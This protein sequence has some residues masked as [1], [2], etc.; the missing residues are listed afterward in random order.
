M[1]TFN[2]QVSTQWDGLR[3]FGYLDDGRFYNGVTMADIHGVGER[4]EKSTVNGIQGERDTWRNRSLP[5][6]FRNGSS[7]GNP[8]SPETDSRRDG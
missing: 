7:A 1:W 3:H 8:C 2:S 5:S 4:G 6:R